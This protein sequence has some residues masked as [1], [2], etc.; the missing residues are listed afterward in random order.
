MI[1]AKLQVT[2]EDIAKGCRAKAEY[3]PVARAFGRIFPNHRVLVST[4]AIDVWPVYPEGF[5]IIPHDPLCIYKP[6]LHARPVPDEIQLFIE[7][8]D[9][10]SPVEPFNVDVEFNSVA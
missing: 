9:N 2:S 10:G 5:F 4:D 8:F 6:S 7:K 3:C 1:V